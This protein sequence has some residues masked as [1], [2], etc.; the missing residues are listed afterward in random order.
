MAKKLE[1]LMLEYETVTSK[2]R[3]LT[4]DELQQLAGGDWYDFRG[5]SQ[6]NS[7]PGMVYLIACPKCNGQFYAR[8]E[9]AGDPNTTDPVL[10][11]RCPYCNEIIHDNYSRIKVK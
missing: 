11:D 6:V 8:T 7:E 9:I 5:T 3:E 2:L 4:E 10:Y 1:L